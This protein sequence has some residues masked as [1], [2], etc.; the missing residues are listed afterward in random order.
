MIATSTQNAPL[1]HAELAE[2]LRARNAFWKWFW[3]KRSEGVVNEPPGPEACFDL[4]IKALPFLTAVLVFSGLAGLCQFSFCSWH[5]PNDD[6]SRRFA[7]YS[8]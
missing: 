6:S 7:M 3:G 1:S 5:L 8:K 4:R 2:F